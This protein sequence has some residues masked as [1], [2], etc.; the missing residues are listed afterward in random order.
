MGKRMYKANHVKS[1]NVEKLAVDCGADAVIGIDV[2]KTK[3]YA[4]FF[5]KG[6]QEVVK[7]VHWQQPE[8]N[9][10]FLSL[11]EALKSQGVSLEAAMEPSGTY[12][13]VIRVSLSVRGV[14]VFQVSGMRVN[15]ARS[16]QDGVLSLH[17]AKSA[18]LIAWLHSTGASQAWEEKSEHERAI[19]A[20]NEAVVWLQES[21][22]RQLGRLEAKLARHW[23][24]VTLQLSLKSATLRELVA[25]YGSPGAVT[26]SKEEARALMRRRGRSFLSE[27]V[28]DAVLESAGTTQ[29][30]VMTEVE[31]EVMREFGAEMQRTA[32]LLH[33]AEERLLKVSHEHV[34]RVAAE[35]VGHRT[36]AMMLAHGVDPAKY[37]SSGALLKACGLNLRVKSSGKDEGRLRISKGGSGEVRQIFYLAVLRLIQKDEWAKAWFQKKRERDGNG[38]SGPKAVV[39]VM[40][41]V[42]K[43]LWHVWTKNESFDSTRL[44]DTARLARMTAE[45]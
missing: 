27:D 13:D 25:T 29:G 17:D 37:E 40:R 30:V 14:P 21:L 36:A 24:E 12:G 9:R 38:R 10:D 1:V 33:K 2:A 18:H 22:Q 4:A 5:S 31:V 19:S 32:Q 11:C 28:I 15:S 34:P 45:A 20:A 16:I 8:E 35:L 39:A 23:P 7:T 6:T 3:Q 42:V 41:K 26:K 43:A 44:F